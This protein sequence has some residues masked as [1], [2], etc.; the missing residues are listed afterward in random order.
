MKG[1]LVLALALGLPALACGLA[2]VGAPDEDTSTPDASIEGDKVPREDTGVEPPKVD[3]GDPPEESLPEIDA[4]GVDASMENC[5]ASSCVDAGGG[6]DAGWCVIERDAGAVAVACP[7]GIPC[8]VSCSGPD[9]CKDG[10]DCASAGACDIECRGKG[11]CANDRVACSGVLCN[12]ACVGDGACVAGV[13][14]DAGQCDV[15]CIGKDACKNS[16]VTCNADRCT[17]QC[18]RLDGGTGK[19]TCADGV[20]CNATSSCE[21]SCN[22]DD[23]CKN[24]SVVATAS[25]SVDVWCA[26]RNSCGAPVRVAGGSAAVHCIGPGACKDGVRCDGG[27]CWGECSD[28]NTKFCCT[29]GSTGCDAGPT[30]KL[31]QGSCN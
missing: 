29:P 22:T 19:D 27:S 24:D 2:L 28:K 20:V 18:G 4:A 5:L 9:T 30:C 10:V 1:R 21:V 31:D 17:V 14:C 3:A 11:A 15:R 26:G 7:P 25:E 8:R 23:S 12:V 16:G 13:A 6:C